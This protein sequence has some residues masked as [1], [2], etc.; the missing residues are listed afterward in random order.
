VKQRLTQIHNFSD[1][2][3]VFRKYRDEFSIHANG[4]VFHGFREISDQMK[5]VETCIDRLVYTIYK[6]TSAEAALIE[7]T[8]VGKVQAKYGWH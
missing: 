6:L 3:D 4:A 1:L 8:T 5:A 2:L 7:N